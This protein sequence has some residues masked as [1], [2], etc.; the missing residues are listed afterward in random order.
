MNTPNRRSLL[1]AAA[2]LGAT[3]AASAQP[4]NEPVI[5]DKGAT[6]VGPRN[7]ERESQNPDILRPPSTD[8]GSVPNL[9]FSFADA[10][11]KIRTGGWSREVT[12]RELAVSTTMAGVN[13]R[14]TSGGVRELHWH[15][16]AEWAFMLAGK[17]RIT[18]VDNDGHSFIADIGPGDL[19]YFPSGIP[20]SIQGLPDDGC[21][22]LLA[23][24]DGE[25]SEDSTFAITDLFAHNDPGVLAKNLVIDTTALGQL[26]KQERF[27]FQAGPP[28]PALE[29]DAVHDALGAVPLDMVF[30]L[31][32]QPPASSPGGNVRIADT[33]N[34]KISTDVAAALVEVNPGHMRELH[35]HPNADEWQYYIAGQARMTVFAAEARAR[36]FDYRAGDV[37]Y[38]P[39]SMSHFIENTGEEPLRFLEL[40]KSPRFMDVSL[41]QWMALTP[42]EL[43]AAH[44]N[45]DRAVIE[46][47]RKDKQPV[48]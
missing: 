29:A 39:M 35:W 18:A 14:L 20:H 32:Q 22:F 40:F 4:R 46:K 2:A 3:A 12:Q 37:G 10:H 28:P 13:M 41:A 7:P 34:F 26:P 27:I 31:T 43:V 21:E 25:F 6:I 15:K 44:L 47:L 9:R 11:M 19:W 48:V 30:H 1:A 23:F 36:T 33:R 5:G 38:V 16:Q 24:P 42:P 45:I 17:A 8:H